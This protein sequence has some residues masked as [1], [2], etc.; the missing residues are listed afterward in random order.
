MISTILLND[1][2]H[3]I[4]IADITPQQDP[5]IT[6]H[7][8]DVKIL[9]GDHAVLRVIADGTKPLHYQWYRKSKKQIPGMLSHIMYMPVF[10]LLYRCR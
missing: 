8:Q 3:L 6:F 5:V 9:A 7:P 4:Y 2:K 1:N 10:S